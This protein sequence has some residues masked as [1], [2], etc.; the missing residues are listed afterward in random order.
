ME[1]NS[2]PGFSQLSVARA[3]EQRGGL[4]RTL[5]FLPGARWAC[6]PGGLCVWVRAGRSR[7]CGP[8]GTPSPP[9]LPSGPQGPAHACR[10]ARPA[11]RRRETRGPGGWRGGCGWLQAGPPGCKAAS[12]MGL[13]H[14]PRAAEETR[15]QPAPASGPGHTG[16]PACSLT[17]SHLCFLQGLCGVES[18]VSRPS[19]V[20]QMR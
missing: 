14:L 15:P 5:S 11:G 2:P 13:G 6:F 17:V 3:G 8:P 9:E 19:S 10:R 16:S 4:M 12:G 20:L 7:R 1:H 18:M